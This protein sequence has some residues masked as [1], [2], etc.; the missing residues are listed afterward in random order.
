MLKYIPNP[1]RFIVLLN[2]FVYVLTLVI[3]VNFQI[4]IREYL[5]L[6]A[7]WD[8]FSPLQLITYSISHSN[9]YTHLMYNM[10]FFLIYG[11]KVHNE[12]GKIPFIL[13][14]FI[15]GIVGGLFFMQDHYTG[16][17]VGASGIVSGYCAVFLLTKVE[18]WVFKVLKWLAALTIL[19]NFIAIALGVESNT[20]Y[21]CHV[22]GIVAGLVWIG[23]AYIHNFLKKLKTD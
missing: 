22:G 18:H 3:G 16:T 21:M 9:T 19:N 2:V 8:A 13:M 4:D 17:V 23:V 5:A 12:Y 14:Y 1:V 10:I 7:S 15:F 11:T 6:H 20:A